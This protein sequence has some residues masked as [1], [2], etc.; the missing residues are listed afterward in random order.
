MNIQLGLYF[1]NNP[2]G[3][4]DAFLAIG[5]RAYDDCIR[6]LPYSTAEFCTTLKEASP[7]C[8]DPIAY[9]QSPMWA[10]SG[11]FVIPFCEWLLKVK[12]LMPLDLIG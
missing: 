2:I 4:M 5:G 6:I 10:D 9:L 1:F 3:G 7:V 12:D 11:L 8:K